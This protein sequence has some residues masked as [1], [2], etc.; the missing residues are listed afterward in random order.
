M[1]FEAGAEGKHGGLRSV[2]DFPVLQGERAKHHTQQRFFFC[3]ISMTAFNT[4]DL[5]LVHLR[6]VL[7]GYDKMRLGSFVILQ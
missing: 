1:G 6:S 4:H 5:F 3:E 7:N 2:C